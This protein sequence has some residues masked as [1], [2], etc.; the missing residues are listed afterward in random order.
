[1][2]TVFI[3]LLVFSFSGLVIGSVIF[4]LPF[5]V[6]TVKSGFQSIP[7]SLI[8]SSYTLGKSRWETF[9]QVLTPINRPAILSGI[10][11]TFAHTLGEFGVVLMVGGNIPRQTRTA[12]IAI[13]NEFEALNYATAHMYSFVLII[14]SFVILIG[15]NSLTKNKAKV[16][17]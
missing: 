9:L 13:Y 16:V 10:I 6:N 11:M 14:I 15:V 17:A 7:V 2:T 12:S 5:M 8:E 4:S 1:M 3:F